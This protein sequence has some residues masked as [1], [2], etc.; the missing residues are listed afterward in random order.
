MT[1]EGIMRPKKPIIKVCGLTQPRDSI[2]ASILGA[3]FCG[4]IFHPNSPRAVKPYAARGLPTP[5]AKRVGV[6]VN[7]SADETMHIMMVACLDLAQL[8]GDQGPEL[9]SALGPE[10]V[11]KVFWP[12]RQPQDELSRLMGLW[13]DQAAYF[14]FDAGTEGGGSGQ[15][16]LSSLPESPRPYLLAGGMSP[17]VAK[18]FWPPEDPMMAG[19][20]FNSCL[21][22]APGIKNPESLRNLLPWRQ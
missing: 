1:L 19:F 14:L 3:D 16:I 10:R 17:V 7:Q 4:F 9:A 12:D 22:E 21:E 11:I 6:F 18:G 8:H 15:M 20:D 2:M 5:G 13:K